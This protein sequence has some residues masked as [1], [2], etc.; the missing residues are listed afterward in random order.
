MKSGQ[1]QSNLA[2]M[3]EY[4]GFQL[5]DI[6]QKASPP[7]SSLLLGLLQCFK[8]LTDSGPSRSEANAYNLNVVSKAVT[9]VS[10]SGVRLSQITHEDL[11]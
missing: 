3:L 2:N 10:K 9:A 7:K 11:T 8:R 4:L 5:L 6:A 1:R